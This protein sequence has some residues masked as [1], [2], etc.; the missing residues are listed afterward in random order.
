MTIDASLTSFPDETRVILD[1][2]RQAIKRAAPDAIE[3]MSYGIP[4]DD[5]NGK[6]LVFF[7]G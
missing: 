6:R 5:R 7:A 4:T 1:D 2:A 3:T